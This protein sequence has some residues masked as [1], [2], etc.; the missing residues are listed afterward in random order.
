MAGRDNRAS[1]TVEKFLRRHLRTLDEPSVLKLYQIVEGSGTRPLMRVNLK[2]GIYPEDDIAIMTS[3]IVECATDDAQAYSTPS[4]YVVYLE[5]KGE[6]VETSGTFRLR[7][8]DAEAEASEPPTATGLQSQLMRHLE[9]RDRTMMGSLGS[10]LNTLIQERETIAQREERSIDR[11]RRAILELEELVS[12]RADR[13]L[14]AK[15][16]ESERAFRE[17]ALDKASVLMPVIANR[18][19]GKR[20]LPHG[21]PVIDVVRM[22][23]KRIEPDKVMLL[24][25]ALGLSE[26]E[27]IA[28]VELH[29]QLNDDGK[30]VQSEPS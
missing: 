27:T 2:A 24:A 21:D 23:M 4:R 17:K 9:A 10:L 6:L 26:N 14:A 7:G 1:G 30:A 19:M 5:C 12:T 25:G 8:S 28:L 11:E 3:D 18:L 20:V 29:S 16:A 13:E 22:I 15:Q